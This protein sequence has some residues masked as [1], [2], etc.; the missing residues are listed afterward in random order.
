MSVYRNDHEAQC[1]VLQVKLERLRTIWICALAHDVEPLLP[2]PS[3]NWPSQ[4]GESSR[5]CGLPASF[6]SVSCDASANGT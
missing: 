4:C 2:V 1:D 5:H 3:T 6:G